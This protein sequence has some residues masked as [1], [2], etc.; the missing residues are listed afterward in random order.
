[1]T[2]PR[3]PLRR[4]ALALAVAASLPVVAQDKPVEMKFGSWV[5]AAHALQKTGFEPWAKSV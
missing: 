2:T 5:P 4:I 3:T 1:M